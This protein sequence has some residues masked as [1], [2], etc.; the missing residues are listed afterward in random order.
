MRVQRL[1]PIVTIALALVACSDNNE[2]ETPA[3][4]AAPV[5]TGRFVDSPVQGARY[6]NQPSG[7]SGVT[8]TNGEFQYRPGDLIRFDFAPDFPAVAQAVITPFTI[9]RPQNFIPDVKHEYPVNVARYLLAVDTTPGTDVIT[10]PPDGQALPPR[11]FNQTTFESDMAAAGIPIVPKEVAIAHLKEQFAIWGSWSTTPTPSEVLV[12]T[13]KPNGTFHVAHDDDP[14]VPGGNDGIELGTYYWN[15]ATS[16][17]TYTV[18]FNGDGTGG[19]S[20]PG[21]G[22]YSFVIDVSG[23]TAVLHLGPT[24][25]QDLHV[26]RLL[27]DA[28]PLIGSWETN[29]W[30]ATAVLTFAPDGN[31]TF[32]VDGIPGEPNGMERGTFTYDASTRILTTTTMVDTIGETGFSR[33]TRL[34]AVS[35][36]TVTFES[37]VTPDLD[38]L[39][40]ESQRDRVWFRRI[41]VP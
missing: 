22:P 2:G 12:I 39:I 38:I 18:T 21:A 16:S 32:A 6:S 9:L 24:A 11:V 31:F 40:V 33:G 34:P 7:L 27:D 10:L 3:P 4:A 41:K 14:L 15:A 23:N 1:W 25:S 30:P 37:S 8:G 36:Q 20:H 5:E 19:L 26:T 28:N 17:F 29:P 35:T 13:F